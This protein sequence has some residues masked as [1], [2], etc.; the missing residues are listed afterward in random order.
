MESS[1]VEEHYCCVMQLSSTTVGVEGRLSSWQGAPFESVM[2]PGH[3]VLPSAKWS[4]QALGKNALAQ[5]EARAGLTG[6]FTLC[7]GL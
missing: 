2:F 6:S 4:F 7:C 5:K 1:D 3:M